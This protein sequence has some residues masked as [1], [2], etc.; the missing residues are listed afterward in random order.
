MKFYEKLRH[1]SPQDI[2]TVV[3][4]VINKCPSAFK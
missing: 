2:G 4:E 1:L 3:N